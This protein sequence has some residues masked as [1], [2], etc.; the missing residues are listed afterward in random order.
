MKEITL[1]LRTYGD[2]ALTGGVKKVEKVTDEHRNLLSLMARIMYETS[3]IGLAAPQVG[4][5]ESLIV[6]DAGSGLYKLVNPVITRSEGSQSME[7]GCLSVPGVGVKVTRAKK[8]VVDALDENG[9]KVRIEAEDLLACVFQH[10]LDHLAGKLIIDYSP[11]KEKI[12]KKL[13]NFKEI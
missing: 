13:Q 5:T 11:N 4:I 7:E 12:I 2:P 9:K 10:E 8:V 6:V 1:R 3:G